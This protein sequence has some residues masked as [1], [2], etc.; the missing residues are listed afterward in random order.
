MVQD[1]MVYVRCREVRQ[2]MI[3]NRSCELQGCFSCAFRPPIHPSEK[4][5]LIL[6]AVQEAIRNQVVATGMEGVF[7]SS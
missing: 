2:V 5:P 1:R 4:G 6:T 3:D 7:Y